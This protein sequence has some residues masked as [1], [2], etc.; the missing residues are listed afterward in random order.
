VK[1][2][3]VSDEKL[4][5]LANRRNCMGGLPSQIST[6]AIQTQTQGKVQISN[7][8]VDQHCF[9]FRFYIVQAVPENNDWGDKLCLR[10]LSALRPVLVMTEINLGHGICLSILIVR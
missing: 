7:P 8:A 3:L 10:R 2:H 5:Y 4:R 1:N 9:E 6:L